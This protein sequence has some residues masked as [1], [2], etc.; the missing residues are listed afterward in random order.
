MAVNVSKAPRKP[1]VYFFLDR[2]GKILYIGKAANL[3]LRLQSYFRASANLEPAKQAMISKVSGFKFKV[4]SSDIEALILEAQLIKKHRPP[5][6]VLFR[7]DKTYLS[8]GFTKEIFTRV[9]L[10]RRNTEGLEPV[11]GPFTD[12]SALKQTLKLLRRVFPYATHKGFPKHCLWRDLGLCP[13]PKQ[14]PANSNQLSDLK[15]EYRRDIKNLQA[16]LKGEKTGLLSKLKKEMAQA[17]KRHDFEKAAKIR[18]EIGGLERV[19]QHRFVVSNRWQI[20]DR[21][22][23]INDLPRTL[24]QLLPKRWPWRIEG[25]DISNIQGTS[26]TGSMIVF[27]CA[28]INANAQSANQCKYMPDKS[29]YRKFRI[30]TVKGANDVAM[31]QEVLSRRL[32]HREWPAPDIILVDGGKPQI[33]A[34]LAVLKDLNIEDRRWKPT[35]LALAKKREEIYV[36]N[37]KEPIGLPQNHPFRLLLMHVRDEAHRFARAYHHKLREIK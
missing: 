26:A 14:K 1:G 35:V 4:T 5:Y 18:D 13:I 24:Q 23:L 9:V 28:R 36:P 15:K 31:M 12:A 10:V 20:A 32:S 33:N 8:V 6:N 30:K 19:F 29:Q 2:K 25:Y 16:V 37:K 17:A 21:E 7:D 3:R 11:I 27:R 22:K 34:A